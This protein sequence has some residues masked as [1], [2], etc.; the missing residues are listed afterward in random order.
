[1]AYSVFIVFGPHGGSYPAKA[2]ETGTV[3]QMVT[4]MQNTAA[5]TLSATTGVVVTSG[6]K[7]VGN[8]ASTAMTYSPTGYNP[9]YSTWEITAAGNAVN[10][11]L[12][13]A[14]STSLDHPIFVVDGYS[15]TQLPASISVGTGLTT[16][17]VD[18]FATLD[19]AGQRLWI[20]VNRLAT[21]P[22]NLIVQQVIA[23]TITFPAIASQTFGTPPITLSA[24]ASSGLP[25]SF[26][27]VSGPA[28]LNGSVL[29]FTG[30]GQVT[31][32]ASQAGN[33]TYSAAP[34]VPQSFTVNPAPL[35]TFSQWEALYAI[36]SAAT[37]TPENDGVTNL[38]K[39][40]GNIDPIRPMTALDRAALPT[41]G[42]DTTTPGTKYLTLTYRQYASQTGLTI[43]VQ[44]SPD[45]HNWT[46]VTPNLTL[47]RGIDPN[48]GDPIVEVEV[49]AGAAGRE[50]IRLNVTTP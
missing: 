13:P 37:G 18:Y 40:L 28:T 9:V 24:T 42:I 19:T 26:T 32:S 7:G 46:T 41:S 45:L 30:S 43:E 6:P 44:T 3:G 21:S 25:V 23:Q 35:L 29:S 38:M 39:Y 34:T 20:S 4:Q 8:A 49:N 31:V 22:V 50:F 11:T 36:S 2:Y 10:A 1:M 17:G 33:A 5:A 48:T 16:A 27:V 12:S 47:Q 15:S 14:A